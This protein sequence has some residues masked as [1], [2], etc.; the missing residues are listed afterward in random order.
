ME[1][2]EGKDNLGNV[3][4]DLALLES[5]SVALKMGK[6]LPAGLVVDDEE[7]VGVGLEAVRDRMDG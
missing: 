3:K 5:S 1:K 4:L 7:E 2:I 6:E